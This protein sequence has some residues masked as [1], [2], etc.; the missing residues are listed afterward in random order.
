M[1]ASLSLESQMGLD[2]KHNSV[3]LELLGQGI[4]L[5]AGKASAEMWDWHL[6]SIYWIEEVETSVVFSHPMANELVSIKAVVLPL[7]RRSSL[8]HAQYTSVKILNWDSQMKWAN[9]VGMV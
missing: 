6:I 4:K 5:L 1:F 8:S 7:G 3:A 2:D 9:F